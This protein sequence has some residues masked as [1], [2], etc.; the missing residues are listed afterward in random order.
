MFDFVRKHTKIMQFLLFLLIVP[1]FVLFGLQGY[2]RMQE[3]GETV[4][5]VDGHEISQLDWDNAHKA[6]VDRLREQMPTLDA[7]MLD[8]AEAR[9]GT[10]ERLVRDRVLAAA[11]QNSNLMVT[12]QRVARE[13][14]GNQLIA[15]LRGADGKLDIERYRQLLA[16]RG[17]TP[18]MFENQVRNDVALTRV[19]GGVTQSAF[20]PPSQ[21]GVAVN[22]FFERREAQVA[23]FNAADYKG[24]VTPT[25]ADLQA[26]YKDNPKLFQAP[27]QASIEYLVLD[28]AAAQQGITINEADL[29]TYYEQNAS[30][31][32]GQEERRASH[33]LVAVPKGAPEAD[34]AKARAKADE[35]L[36][37][38]K[39]NPAGFAELAKKNSQ[40]EGSA[41]RGGD[42]DFF[43]RGAMV[44][45]FEDAVFAMKD[46][47]E[48]AGPVESEFGYHVIQLTDVKVPKQ[49]TFEEMKPEL[50]AE[51][52]K[53][54]AQK[55][56][57]EAAES[58]S[59][60]V[61]EQSESLKPAADKLKL[62]I[63]TAEKV[64]R[65]PAPNTTGPTANVKF[66]A[67]LFSPDAVERKRNTEAVEIGPNQM[68]AGRVT[69]YS[70]A[71]TRPFEEVKDQ[72]REQVVAAKAA[73]LARK[74]GEA[75]LAAWKASPATAEL[76][77]AVP[78][79]RMDAG[80][81][82]QVIEAALRAD[83]AKLPALVG[84]DLGAE[85]YAVVKVNKLLPRDTVAPQQAQQEAGQ[86]TRAWGTAEAMA[87]YEVLKNRFKAQINVPR[88]KEAVAQ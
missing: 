60:T 82:R 35:L 84:V 20:A 78:V 80:Q 22:S 88:P 57:A 55:K 49:R 86:Y 24:K 68:A 28:L 9:Y 42:L 77:A 51:L 34:K 65:T 4:A 44:K 54:Q 2:E 76:P 8:S 27:E 83:P 43:T 14:Q 33:I 52:R 11:V 19:L 59:N 50:E 37:Q 39:K 3:K 66:L 41:Q 72:V 62:Q 25:D 56:Y 29:K 23:R 53:Q 87:Y 16:Q 70:P 46:K 64:T 47:G 81:P 74:D 85:G 79:S 45:P 61:Y 17:M 73:E 38:V 26:F 30:R 40:D 58:F 71:R 48:I 36:A 69:Q 7:K 18:E 15:A 21:V 5:K 31:I 13:L 63:R 10:L 1:S 32:G 67:A 6:E 75:K 12:D